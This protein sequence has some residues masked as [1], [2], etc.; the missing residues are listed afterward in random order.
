MKILIIG[1]AGFIGLNLASELAKKD[2]NKITICDNF[3]RGK[4]DESFQSL[5]A[6][7]VSFI[8]ADLTVLSNFSKLDKDYDHVYMLAS[9]VGVG[10][11]YDIPDKII[12][13]NTL[14]ILNV[15]DWLKTS[16]CKRVLFTSTSEC[17]A[18]SIDHFGYQ[19]PTPESVPL[20]IEDIKNPRFTYAATK[21]LG[22]SAFL[23]YGRAY[24]FES[25]I[26]RYHNVYGPRMGFKHVIPQVSK[27]LFDNENPFL[28]YGHNQTRSFNYIS[29]AVNGTIL[30][31]NSNKTDQEII[32]IG[33]MRSEI[34]IIELVKYIS[35]LMGKDP[36]FKPVDAP[37]GSVAR[38]CP[39][40]SLAKKLTGYEPKINWQ[41]G[42]QRTVNW[43]HDFYKTGSNLF[44]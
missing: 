3:F 32:H 20:C 31:M 18:G 2:T 36:E 38:R 37:K 6:N 22:E 27:R 7:G 43:Y 40:T 39:D 9:I 23:Q 35:N 41:D 44:E 33:D 42:V 15:L 8:E 10:Y 19:V 12:K 13:T 24:S 25:V 16:D 4:N 26:V 14:L 11:T 34:S 30:A 1:G 17:Y 28:V 29:D 21:L 5:L